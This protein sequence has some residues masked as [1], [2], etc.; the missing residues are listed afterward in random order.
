MTVFC[1]TTGAYA[2]VTNPAEVTGV[3]VAPNPTVAGDLDLS[4]SP[5]T[6]DVTGHPETVSLYNIYRGDV[7]H[8]IPDKSGKSNLVGTSTTSTFTDAGARGDGVDHYYLVSA[9]DTA[10][11]EGLTRASRAT[12]PPA[13]SGYWTDTTIELSWTD[14]LPVD[15]VAGYRVYY[16][17]ASGV[18]DFVDDVGLTN[19][20][21][22]TGL[23]LWVNW[24]IAVTAV[25]L[26]GNESVLSNEHIDPV[27]GRV[28]AWAQN[29]S[30]LCWGAAKCPPA[31]GE[32]Q[33]ADGW[34]LMTPIDL[35]EG[36]WT[37]VQLKFT[38]ASKLCEPPAGQ[39]V[40]RCGSG[41]PCLNP[42]CNGGYNT[43]GD[44]WDRTAHV[45]LVLD[46]CIQT[47]ANCRNNNNLELMRAITSFGTD[48]P[49]PDGRGIVPP[50]ELTLDITPYAPLLAGSMYV[51]TEIGHYVQTGHWVTVEFDFS[52]RPEE[53]SP[54]PPADGIHV[55]FYGG[56]SPPRPP[57]F[58]PPHA[59]QG[60]TPAFHTRRAAIAES[61]PR[62]SRS[63][64]SHPR[65]IPADSYPGIDPTRTAERA[66]RCTANRRR[67]ACPCSS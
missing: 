39:N 44:P 17:K 22:L 40:S 67:R 33:Q 2:D 20:Y 48:A 30:E 31:P 27:A 49:T 19:S 8:F 3:A 6:T 5:V 66:E 56:G 47:G 42:P 64:R 28:K 45:F 51:G 32:V 50:R 15:Q 63:P 9:E 59:P 38:M 60:V 29:D 65:T 1:L 25:D 52:K 18:Y 43:C 24:Y 13:L 36:N 7:P 14:A 62:S 53:A 21:S 12:T 34:R 46:D 10:G 61:A 11:N 35:P 23:E 58:R 41:N 37:S 57:G 16:G 26:D 4:W 54:K 55:L